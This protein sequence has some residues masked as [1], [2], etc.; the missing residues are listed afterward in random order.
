M[1]M[2]LVLKIEKKYWFDDPLLLVDQSKITHYCTVSTCER[3]VRLKKPFACVWCRLVYADRQPFHCPTQYHP[4]QVAKRFTNSFTLKCNV[5]ESAPLDDVNFDRVDELSP[6]SESGDEDSVSS[7][8]SDFVQFASTDNGVGIESSYYVVEGA[9]CSPSCV[10]AFINDNLHNPVYSCSEQLLYKMT[11]TTDQIRE[12]PHWRL[13]E[14]YGGKLSDQEMRNT[15]GYA[16][17]KVQQNIVFINHLYE[18]N[19]I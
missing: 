10:M 9:F 19:I 12:S 15:I 14:L 2:N 7:A 18:K 8:S 13:H 6:P 5:G 1:R 17:F 3:L 4:R 11:S 16:T